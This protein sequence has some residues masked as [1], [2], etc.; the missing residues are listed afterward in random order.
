[1][2][3]EWNLSRRQFMGRSLSALAGAAYLPTHLLAQTSRPTDAPADAPWSEDAFAGYLAY[4]RERLLRCEADERALHAAKVEVVPDYER[5]LERV[6]FTLR[7][8]Q[9]ARLFRGLVAALPKYTKIV[10]VGPAESGASAW[11]KDVSATLGRQVSVVEAVESAFVEVW[12]QDVLER[13]TVD[14][15]GAV[16]LPLFYRYL[17]AELPRS[18]PRQGRT[19]VDGLGAALQSSIGER[20]F[21][22]PVFFQGG[23]LAFDRVDGVSV[24]LTSMN[25]VVDTRRYYRQVVG[26]EPSTAEILGRLGK[27]F[28][29]SRVEVLTDRESRVLT[30]HID[31]N[32]CLLSGGVALVTRVVEDASSARVLARP[33]EIDFESRR[34]ETVRENLARLKYRIVDIDVTK[35]QLSAAQ[36][37]LN[38]IPF[39]NRETDERTFLMPTWK[40]LSP[41]EAALQTRNIERIAAEGWKPTLILDEFHSGGG[42]LHCAVNVLN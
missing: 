42:N 11:E 26:K 4:E 20:A 6:L 19:N 40:D 39:R 30:M 22:A 21:L 10:V 16:V 14:D 12:A 17:S 2:A 35:A 33:E 8:P 32:C 23:D 37:P 15:K 38:G 9:L 1:M 25:S 3:Y 5:T 29:V 24:L 7:H 36:I 13:V 41:G 34:C 27:T 31:Q 18:S 28:G